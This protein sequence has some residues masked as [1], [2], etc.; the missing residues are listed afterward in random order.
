MSFGAG[1][2]SG[3][4]AG[5]GSGIAVGMISGKRSANVAMEKRLRDFAATHTIT[6]RDAEDR[7]I[8]FDEFVQEIVGAEQEGSGR[9]VRVSGV[10]IGLLVLGLL[11]AALFAFL[12]IQR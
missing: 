8:P 6:V 1:F 11:L 3:M 9:A 12:L 4:G 7:E 5:M 2:G 10:L